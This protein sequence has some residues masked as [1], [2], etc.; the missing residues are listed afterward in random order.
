MMKILLETR[1]QVRQNSVLLKA[2]QPGANQ[3]SIDL[4]EEFPTLPLSTEKDVDEMNRII[5]E[6]D[7]MRDLVSILII[8]LLKESVTY[9]APIIHKI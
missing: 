8:L 1:Q 2:M 6:K 4:T 5:M 3:L 7:K 9:N